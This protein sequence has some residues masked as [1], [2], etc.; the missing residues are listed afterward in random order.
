MSKYGVISGPYFP[1]LGL[2]TESASGK[3]GTEI[4]PYLD[5]FHAVSPSKFEEMKVNLIEF[6]KLWAQTSPPTQL[7]SGQEI[8]Q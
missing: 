3:Y 4:T 2:N 1:V 7:E 8:N 5:T 6:S